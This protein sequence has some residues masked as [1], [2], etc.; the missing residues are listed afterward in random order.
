[1]IFNIKVKRL[2]VILIISNKLFIY[3][4]NQKIATAGHGPTIKGS[5][6]TGTTLFTPSGFPQLLPDS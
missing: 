2:S 6:M 3:Q 1:M 4:F 5:T